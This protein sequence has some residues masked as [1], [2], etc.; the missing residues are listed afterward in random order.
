MP[1]TY[2]NS[3]ADCCRVKNRSQ[4]GMRLCCVCHPFSPLVIALPLGS[5][6]CI[7]T[8]LCVF[9]LVWPKTPLPFCFHF[10]VMPLHSPSTKGMSNMR[11][12][13]GFEK[14]IGVCGSTCNCSNATSCGTV[15]GAAS[16]QCGWNSATGTCLRRLSGADCGCLCRI[17]VPLTDAHFCYDFRKERLTFP[18]SLFLLF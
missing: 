5:N 9:V 16:P 4:S 18:A 13:Y 11:T 3:L 12:C 2:W 6:F 1:S 8:G 15:G 17:Y 10:Q 7:C 14:R